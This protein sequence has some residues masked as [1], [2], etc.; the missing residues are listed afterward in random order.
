MV[1]KN[2]V[3]MIILFMLD[4]FINNKQHIGNSA[5]KARSAHRKLKG[6]YRVHMTTL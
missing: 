6:G 1:P 5:V 3:T 4:L 2:I